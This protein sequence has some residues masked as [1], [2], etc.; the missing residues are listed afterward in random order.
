MLIIISNSC[1][2]EKQQYT[3]T[4]EATHFVTEENIYCDP[5]A[6]YGWS[7]EDK[8]GRYKFDRSGHVVR[9]TISETT[10]AESGDWIFIYISVNDVFDYGSVSCKSSDGSIFLYANTDNLYIDESD[11]ETLK[12]VIINDKDTIIKVRELKFKI[13]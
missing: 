11:S 2:K 8:D 5:Y 10:T 4:F 3:L 13:I 1:S 9:G 7:V 12:H 6:Y